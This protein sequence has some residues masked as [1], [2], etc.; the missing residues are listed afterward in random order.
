MLDPYVLVLPWITTLPVPTELTLILPLSPEA[1]TILALP[2]LPLVARV[3]PAVIPDVLMVVDPPT[4]LTDVSF[5]VKFD[6]VPTEVIELE[7][8]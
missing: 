7:P 1:M 4:K 6:R 8:V 5:V 3:R 2:T